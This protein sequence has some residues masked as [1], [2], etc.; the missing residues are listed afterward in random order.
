[1]GT[2]TLCCFGALEG[3]S[4]VQCYQFSNHLSIFLR[5]LIYLLLFWMLG[6]Q[7]MPSEG[8]V[9]LEKK[10]KVLPFASFELSPNHFILCSQLLLG[11]SFIVGH[12]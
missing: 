10:K 11:E 12:S 9:Q 2:S 3:P 1:M 5:V 8:D 4:W 7:N 6:S